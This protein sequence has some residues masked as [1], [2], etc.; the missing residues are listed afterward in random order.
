MSESTSTPSLFPVR[1][2]WVITPLTWFV[3]RASLLSQALE[4]NE[5]EHF[6][7]NW[8]QI[9][10]SGTF[11]LGDPKY[12]YPPGA[13]LLFWAIEIFPVEFHRTFTM[14]VIAA[15]LATLV[16]LLVAVAKRRDSWAGPWAWTLG[17]FLAGGL[18]YERF[19]TFPTLLAV[20]SLLL[21]ARPMTMGVITGVGLM[22]KTWPGIALFAVPRREL[23]RAVIGTLIGVAVTWLI[24]ALIASNSTSFITNQVSRGLQIETVAAVPVLLLGVLGVVDAPMIDRYGSTELDTPLGTPLVIISMLTGAVLIIWLLIARLRGRLEHIPGTDVAFTALLVFV[25]FNKVNSPEYIIW[26]AGIG[27]VAVLNARSRMLPPLIMA[28]LA[29]VP[30]MVFLGPNYG[31]LQQQT[32]EAVIFQSMRGLLLLASALTAWVIVF[33]QS[34]AGSDLEREG[35]P[36]GDG[37]RSELGPQ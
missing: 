19:D 17:G 35:R 23:P 5:N 1:W 11:P 4:F 12:Q 10:A 33:Q 25:A 24:A 6:Y 16:L 31:L 7:Q 8:G 36:G 20:A 32:I 28:G 37:V 22:V 29:M 14:A 30:V 15:D 9:V 21:L 18:I 34:R 2:L 3:L 27:A 13:G 26:I